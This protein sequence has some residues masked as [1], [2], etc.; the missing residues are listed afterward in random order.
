MFGCIIQAHILGKGKKL[1]IK[2]NQPIV[3]TG[4]AAEDAQWK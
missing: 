3:E 2:D 4:N 1:T